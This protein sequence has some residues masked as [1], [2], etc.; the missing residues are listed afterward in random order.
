MVKLL[1]FNATKNKNSGI[2]TMEQIE[3]AIDNAVQFNCTP[4][5]PSL[6]FSGP[7]MVFLWDD[8]GS[9][10]SLKDKLGLDRPKDFDCISATASTSRGW[11]PVKNRLD[12]NSTYRYSLFIEPDWFEHMDENSV[13]GIEPIHL[14]VSGLLFSCGLKTMRALDDYYCNGLI[15]QRRKVGIRKHCYKNVVVSAWVYFTNLS[16]F[17]RFDPHTNKYKFGSTFEAEA[18]HVTTQNREQVYAKSA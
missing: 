18:C 6:R 7:Q 5:L 11:V 3:K 2:K 13:K 8:M 15:H 12:S 9:S 10:V 16:S 17:C 4:D 1:D 14:P